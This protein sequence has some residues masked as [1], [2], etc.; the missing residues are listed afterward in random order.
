[1]SQ[2]PTRFQWS[3]VATEA[4]ELIAEGRLTREQIANKLD[5]D[6]RTLSRWLLNPEFRDRVN[7]HRRA[8]REAIRLRGI[9]NVE[10]RLSALQ[11]RW[12]RANEVIQERAADPEMARI[13]GG[14][15]GL[16]TRSTRTR[17][18]KLKDG[19]VFTREQED[20]RV[21]VALLKELREIEE[22]AAREVGDRRKPC[23]L[24]STGR[25]I[26]LLASAVIV[27]AVRL[28]E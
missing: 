26:G 13:P 2:L 19:T 7:E 22:Q 27:P 25:T 6:R 15:T 8:F 28:A 3:G 16:L 23:G 1:M 24:T 20:I 14:T 10:A 21:D 18:R 11:D 9:G 12:D 5:I 4:A 17:T